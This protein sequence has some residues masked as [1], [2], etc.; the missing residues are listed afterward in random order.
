[1]E[2][3]YAKPAS[4]ANIPMHYCPGCTHGIAH[5]LICE[6]I[7]ELGIREKTIGVCGI[8]CSFLNY[9][10]I[11]VVGAA[12]GKAPATA[13]GVKR[14]MPD[15]FVFTYQGDG[16]CSAIGAAEVLHAAARQEK[17]SVFMVSNTVFAMTGGQKSPTTL[18]GQ[19]TTTTQDGRDP[20]RDGLPIREAE[21]IAQIPGSYYVARG[22]LNSIA[23][24]AK[25]KKY[26]KKSIEYQL[27][28]KGMCF[29]EL[30]STCPTNWGL[31][32]KESLDRVQNEMIPYYPL[33]EI[34]VPEGVA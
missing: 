21:I 1:M 12:H 28:G 11:D 6:V 18:I 16:D 4:L 2:K 33:G 32:P 22:A 26:V 25:A 10:D 9:L 5:K 24:I 3:V 19:R 14:S 34:K 23:N 8:G 15:K 27:A 17:I 29:V 7:D 31:S 20:E 30:L 13:T